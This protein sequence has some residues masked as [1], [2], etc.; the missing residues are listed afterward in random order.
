MAQNTAE[1]EA[2]AAVL[3]SLILF[4]VVFGSCLS[5]SVCSAHFIMSQS[6]NF[7]FTAAIFQFP[8]QPRVSLFHFHTSEAK[9]TCA[10]LSS[11]S[12]AAAHNTAPG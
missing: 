4:A 3:S 5:D 9:A 1:F 10:A 11:L 12:A 6:T 2:S 8:M 7:G